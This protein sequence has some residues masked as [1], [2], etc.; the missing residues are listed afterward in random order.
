MMRDRE[1]RELS[2]AGPQS[3]ALDTT[4]YWTHAFRNKSDTFFNSI[5][6]IVKTFIDLVEM[7]QAVNAWSLRPPYAGAGQWLCWPA[8]H[9]MGARRGSGVTGA[10]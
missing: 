2:R 9:H 5:K 8:Q 10:Q 4:L 3:G 7:N 6:I 1:E